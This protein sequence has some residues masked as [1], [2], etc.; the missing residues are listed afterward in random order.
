MANNYDRY[1][2]ERRQENEFD[3]FE[4]VRPM[5]SFEPAKNDF[6]RSGDKYDQPPEPLRPYQHGSHQQQQQQH[7]Q[8]LHPFSRD[9]IDSMFTVVD[10]D[11]L[12]CKLFYFFFFGAFGSLFPLLAIYFKQLGM[13]AAQSGVLIGFR[14]FIEFLSAPFWG[15]LADKWRRGKEM[16]LFA[17]LCWIVFTLA[18][19]FV[20]PPA[21]KCLAFNGTHNILEETLG[22]RRR[23]DVI[24]AAEFSSR[25]TSSLPLPSVGEIGKFSDENYWKNYVYHGDI[26]LENELS[27]TLH[28][29]HGYIPSFPTHDPY[30]QQYRHNGFQSPGHIHQIQDSHT[31]SMHSKSSDRFKEQNFPT[32]PEPNGHSPS[33]QRGLRGSGRY[34]EN[35][36]SIAGYQGDT[37]RA[38]YYPSAHGQRFRRTPYKPDV[39]KIANVN[40]SDIKGL[41]FNMHSTVVYKV[42][43]LFS[44]VFIYLNND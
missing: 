20:K 7:G 15:G 3:P 41:V 43:V 28:L 4:K 14:P 27:N 16:L 37:L 30:Q 25:A 23:R 22:S 38:T 21:H 19:A 11:L 24:S 44:S 32:H 33:W 13:S 17:L 9:F 26:Q 36:P 40:S 10:K 8:K 18:I 12:F 35:K 6:T 1:E 42:V 34:S 5:N 39:S 2:D 29:S 31:N